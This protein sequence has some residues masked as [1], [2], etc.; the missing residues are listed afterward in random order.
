M[1]P[2]RPVAQELVMC[3]GVRVNGSVITDYNW[4]LAVHDVVQI[5]LQVHNDIKSLFPLSRWNHIKYRLKFSSFFYTSWSLLLFIFMRW[6]RRY[7]V[8]EE[9]ALTE[10]WIRYYIRYFPIKVAKYKSPKVVWLK[11]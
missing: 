1:A 7:E 3:G 9:S 10:R 6:P 11:Y 2:N 5:D 8:V 4:I